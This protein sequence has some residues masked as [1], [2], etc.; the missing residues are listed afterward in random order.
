[1]PIN[2]SMVRVGFNFQ[3]ARKKHFSQ[4]NIG[5]REKHFWNHHVEKKLLLG[6]VYLWPKSF[7]FNRSICGPK[8]RHKTRSM[9]PSANLM[10]AASDH[11]LGTSRMG[12]KVR[13]LS[14]NNNFC[15]MTFNFFLCQKTSTETRQTV[16]SSLPTCKLS[17]TWSANGLGQL[18]P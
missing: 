10:P 7:T 17:A 8:D 3:R 9:V 6:E 4:I 18:Q 14:T 15:V 13:S 11:R 5:W 1:M 2:W 16:P 12:C